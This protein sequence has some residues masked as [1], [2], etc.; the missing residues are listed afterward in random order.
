MHLRE[1]LR[2]QLTASLA[3]APYPLRDADELARALPPGVRFWADGICLGPEEVCG[4]LSPR[5]FL[6][7]S[8]AQVADLVASRACLALESQP[9]H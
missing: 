5:D 4:L 2:E 8:P 9:L 6:F 1:T 7:T 3:R